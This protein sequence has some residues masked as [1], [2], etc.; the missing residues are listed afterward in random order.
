MKLIDLMNSETALIKLYSMELPISLSFKIKMNIKE[1]KPVLQ[2]FKEKRLEIFKKY[3]TQKGNSY[4]LPKDMPEEFNKALKKLDELG[5]TEIELQLQAISLDDFKD[6]KITP[7][8]LE[9]I[10]YMLVL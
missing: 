6:V 4:E 10:E 9:K 3:G 1:I 5:N 7:E 8:L 2:D